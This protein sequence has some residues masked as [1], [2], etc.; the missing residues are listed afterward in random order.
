[1]SAHHL[2]TC[3]VS[4]YS[5]SRVPS[6][7]SLLKQHTTSVTPTYTIPLALT[8][9]GVPV[10]SHQPAPGKLHSHSLSLTHTHT[11]I[12]IFSPFLSVFA[13]V[14][15]ELTLKMLH[16]QTLQPPPHPHQ[17]TSSVWV[18]LPLLYSSIAFSLNTLTITCDVYISCD[19][20]FIILIC[21][22]QA[23]PRPSDTTHHTPTSAQQKVSI[24]SIM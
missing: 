2:L 14:R 16:E 9:A 15:P 20:V 21:L 4:L 1:M 24:I 5:T 6:S 18:S 3:G 17:P 10:T 11:L 19:H 22:L 13:P 8:T 12:T 7:S 23:Q